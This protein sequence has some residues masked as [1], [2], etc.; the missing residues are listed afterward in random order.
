MSLTPYGRSTTVEEGYDHPIEP[1]H[2]GTGDWACYKCGRVLMGTV[3][4]PV[5]PWRHKPEKVITPD[6]TVA[7]LPGGA[8]TE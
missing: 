2:R 6:V 3:L 1:H 5:I 8:T 4:N 7:R